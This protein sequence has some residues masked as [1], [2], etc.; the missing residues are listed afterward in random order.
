MFPQGIWK[1]EL[2]DYHAG[3]YRGY[4]D[5]ITHMIELKFISKFPNF[6]IIP[7]KTENVQPEIASI[8]KNF[9][10]NNARK[11]QI[12][13]FIYFVNFLLLIINLT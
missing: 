13:L 4:G 6:Q 1:C 5:I 2:E 12:S 9:I 8:K 3:K 10:E 11:S 7:N